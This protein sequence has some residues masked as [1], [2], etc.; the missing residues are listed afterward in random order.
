MPV[1]KAM[2]IQPFEINDY[3][4]L[5]I[6]YKAGNMKKIHKVEENDPAIMF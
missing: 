2:F 3:Q 6:K 4:M 1:K 5:A